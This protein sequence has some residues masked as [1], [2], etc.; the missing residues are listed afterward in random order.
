MEPESGV[1]QR[2]N[3]RFAPDA[4]APE[5]LTELEASINSF[6]DNSL[7][8]VPLDETEQ[9][10]GILNKI[11]TGLD[12]QL[13]S[14][15]AKQLFQSLSVAQTDR[16]VII[17]QS[18]SLVC[19]L[20]SFSFSLSHL[21]CIIRSSANQ[22]R[23]HVDRPDPSSSIRSRSFTTGPGYAIASYRSI[24]QSSTSSPQTVE[25]DRCHPLWWADED[26]PSHNGRTEGCVESH[27]YPRINAGEYK[28][29]PRE[30]C[31]LAFC[32]SRHPS[33]YNLPVLQKHILEAIMWSGLR[34]PNILPLLGLD[35][36][37][38]DGTLSLVSP[39]LDNGNVMEYMK[40]MKKNLSTTPST[41]KL[42][43]WV[44]PDYL[45]SF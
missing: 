28:R 18:V 43:K 35:F 30:G 20:F 2:L 4:Q 24:T 10:H 3:L 19:S 29:G 22:T 21:V 45:P 41:E 42:N 1:L 39:W 12:G 36:Q 11:V 32:L 15:E 8:N 31:F 16:A 25:Q 14:S 9:D 26:L 34:H 23:L 7:E 6:V 13:T 27:T 17:I 5:I 44:K 37:A 38:Q 33:A 40:K